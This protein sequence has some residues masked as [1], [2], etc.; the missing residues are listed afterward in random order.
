M[1]AEE[2]FLRKEKFHTK[3]R[4]NCHVRENFVKINKI[5]RRRK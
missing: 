4:Y 2:N 1:L 3:L 5:S